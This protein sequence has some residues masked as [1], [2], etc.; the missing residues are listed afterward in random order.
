M[1]KVKDIGFHDFRHSCASLLID[2]VA[3][4]TLFS[5]YLGHTKLMKT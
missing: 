1:A 3:N 2:S 5:K 4:I